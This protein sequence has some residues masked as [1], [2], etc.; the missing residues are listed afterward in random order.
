MRLPI[1]YALTYPKRLPCPVKHIP[2]TELCSL[3]F[4]Q[5]DRETF[6]CLTLAERAA[7]EGG[8]MGAALCGAGEAAVEAFLAGKCGFLEI[9]ERIERALDNTPYIK[10]PAVD[11]ILQTVEEVKHCMV[12]FRR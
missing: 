11:D 6:R 10:N 3:T 1:Q 5:P 2:F 4:G 12:F 9:A 7:R 8:N